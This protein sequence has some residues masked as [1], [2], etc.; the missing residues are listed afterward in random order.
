MTVVLEYIDLYYRFYACTVSVV[1][2][3]ITLKVKTYNFALII[4]K[5]YPIIPELFLILSNT[6]YSRNY[7]GIIDGSLLSNNLLGLPSITA[8][9]ILT[10]INDIHS[11]ENTILSTFQDLFQ[12][13]GKMPCEYEIK[14]KP[15][16]KPYSLFTARKIPIPLHDKVQ[17]ELKQMEASGVISNID[18]PTTWCSHMVVVQKKSGGIWICIDL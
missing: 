8:L 6:Y 9:N 12:G 5:N 17:K 2:S 10:K 16:A 3:C 18:Q 13:L 11:K 14:L 7:S 15:D 4:P 1:Y